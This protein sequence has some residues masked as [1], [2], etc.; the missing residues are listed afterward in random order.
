MLDFI[1][2]SFLLFLIVLLDPGI[3]RNRLWNYEWGW[4]ADVGVRS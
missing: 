1:E 4:E 3:K 2:M